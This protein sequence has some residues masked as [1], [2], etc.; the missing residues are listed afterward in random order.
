MISIQKD[1][2]MPAPKTRSRVMVFPLKELTEAGMSFFVSAVQYA[3]A[4]E[5]FDLPYLEPYLTKERLHGAIRQQLREWPD[6]KHSVRKW[7][8][9][10]LHGYR[11]WRIK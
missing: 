8:E 2:P 1:V 6:R 3:D 4:R 9:G 11:V 5:S 7:S 10:G